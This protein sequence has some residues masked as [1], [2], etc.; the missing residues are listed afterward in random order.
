M[1]CHKN[2]GHCQRQ[3]TQLLLP[4]RSVTGAMPEYFYRE[5]CNEAW[6]TGKCQSARFISKIVLQ[7]LQGKQFYLPFLG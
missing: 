3:C 4:L 5:V 1:V 6:P 2:V 7:K